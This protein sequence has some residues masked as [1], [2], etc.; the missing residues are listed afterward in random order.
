MA[1]RA[2]EKPKKLLVYQ[3]YKNYKTALL[4]SLPYLFKE[5]PALFL[6]RVIFLHLFGVS[7]FH[8]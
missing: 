7:V 6:E 1:R 2:F 3:K 4:V 5:I 8:L